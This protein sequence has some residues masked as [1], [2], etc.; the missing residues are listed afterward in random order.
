[1]AVNESMWGGF[2]IRFAEYMAAGGR[3]MQKTMF[4]PNFKY[5]NQIVNRLSKI[6][7]AREVILNS[8]LV[9]KWQ[10]SLRKEALIRSAHSSTSI[11]GNRLNIFQVSELAMGRDIMALRKDKQEVLN[12]LKILE[13]LGQLVSESEITEENILGIHKMLTVDTLDNLSDCGS[14]RNHYVV[15][16]NR[17][18]GDVIFRP[19]SNEAVPDL[20]SNLLAWINAE[21]TQELDPRDRVRN[22]PL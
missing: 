4:M 11:E 19:P 7:V 16:A 13:N 18:T 8:P 2:C 21:E 14:Y 10:V 3:K 22:S 6:A 5:T 12:Y 9:P 1:M 17:M 15:V 20:V